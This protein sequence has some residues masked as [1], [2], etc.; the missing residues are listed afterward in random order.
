MV[1]VALAHP[2]T[3][4][5]A[6]PRRP[7]FYLIFFYISPLILIH[8]FASAFSFSFTLHV[9]RGTEVWASDQD[10]CAS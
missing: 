6:G 4:P 5:K 7:R 9:A 10:Q 2:M 1:R 3:I 8:V